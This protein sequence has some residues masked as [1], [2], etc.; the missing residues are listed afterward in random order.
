MRMN[1][2]YKIL[3]PFEGRYNL[4]ISPNCTLNLSTKQSFDRGCVKEENRIGKVRSI[5]RKHCLPKLNVIKTIILL[6]S[7]KENWKHFNAFPPVTCLYW[8]LPVFL[9]IHGTS[10]W[11]VGEWW[12]D[13]DFGAS[14][15][16]VQT[17]ALPL[18][19]TLN[20]LSNLLGLSVLVYKMAVTSCIE[21]LVGKIKSL[22]IQ[23]CKAK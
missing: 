13:Q 2:N 19:V 20:T 15:I 10:S 16:L 14:W 11:T 18:N 9:W 8:E 6:R 21:G 7:F 22:S 23:R 5:F 1:G 12:K 4:H 3:S 17:P